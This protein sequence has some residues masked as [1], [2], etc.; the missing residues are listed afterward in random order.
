M[1]YPLLYFQ[2]AKLAKS[3]Q[4]RSAGDRSVILR[5]HGD[6]PAETLHRIARC[7]ST[8]SSGTGFQSLS[9]T[10]LCSRVAPCL[11]GVLAL[12]D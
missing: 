7:G 1:P 2:L 4:T 12:S 3:D 6:E 8:M 11:D 10:A 9:L 5:L